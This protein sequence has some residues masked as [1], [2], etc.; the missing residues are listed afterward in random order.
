MR[1]P[2]VFARKTRP[3]L[4][5]TAAMMG[6][7]LVSLDVSVVNVALNAF[8]T[9]FAIRMDGLQWVLNVYTLTYAVSLLS[10]G[11]LSDRLGSRAVFMIGSIVFT[12]ASLVCGLAPSFPVLLV[13]RTVQHV[14]AALLV[15]SSMAL[16]QQAFPA[17][18][19]RARA[20]RLRAGADS[21]A[22]SALVGAVA[23]VPPDRGDSIRRL[24]STT[25]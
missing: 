8:R 13:S 19:E 20:V 1:S 25:G 17:A 18:S 6:I 10:A 2:G 16:L 12:S 3:G 22:M 5:L 24:T 14:G 23:F 4:V 21:L 11:A 15:P 9:S 7:V